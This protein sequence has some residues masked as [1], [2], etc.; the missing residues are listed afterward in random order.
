M[1]LQI[2]IGLLFTVLPF[3]EL[4]V[5]LPVIIEYCVRNGYS[6]WP[7]FFLVLVLN[8]A[9]IFLIFLF[10]DFLHERLVRFKGY[11]KSIDGP[12]RRVH[13]KAQKVSKK[14]DDLG[15]VALMLF[16]AVPLP[17]TG[18]W[19]GTLVAWILGLNRTKSIVS[20]SAGV[21]IAGL[22]VLFAFLGLFSSIY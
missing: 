4:R 8:V 11:R 1:D 13:K 5:G 12:L 17:V 7:Y 9:V 19:T 6:V 15:Y 18:A 10:L 21:A 2:L 22:L 14:I 20:I 16:V 3:T